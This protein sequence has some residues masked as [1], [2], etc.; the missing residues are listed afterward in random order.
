MLCTQVYPGR[1]KAL[2]PPKIIIDG[3]KMLVDITTTTK[4]VP[5]W[6]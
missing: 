5:T 1:P 3:G 2:S 6:R 4:I